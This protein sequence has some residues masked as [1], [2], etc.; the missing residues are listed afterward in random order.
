MNDFQINKSFNNCNTQINLKYKGYI[1]SFSN[2]FFEDVVCDSAV[3]TDKLGVCQ[4]KCKKKIPFFKKIFYVVIDDTNPP[5]LT[6]NTKGVNANFKTY[7][8]KDIENV[9]DSMITGYSKLS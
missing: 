5:I 9:Y 6:F 3:Y 2:Y 1:E 7:D 4:I 8:Y